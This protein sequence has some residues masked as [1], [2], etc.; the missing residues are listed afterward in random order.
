MIESF[1]S[2]IQLNRL[3]NHLT[4]KQISQQ[5]GLSKS[6]LSRVERNREGITFENAKLIF[7]IMDIGIVEEDINQQFEKD[8]QKFY[9]DT[10]YLNNYEKSYRVILDY[11]D[12][13][14]ASFSYVKYLLAEMIYKLLQSELKNPREYLYIEKY[15]DYLEDYQK[16]I[17][18]EIIGY[19][20][21]QK[22]MIQES[23]QYYDQALRQ[24]GNTLTKAIL[25]YYYSI[26]LK[27][28]NYLHQSLNLAMK[29]RQIFAETINV[30]RLLQISI[31]I[32]DIYSR[33][34][35]YEE[36]EELTL[37][38]LNAAHQYNLKQYLDNIYENILRNYMR[39]KQYH[40]IIDLENDLIDKKNLHHS[41][42]FCLSFAYYQIQQ[43]DKAKEYIK[44]AKKGT[45][46]KTRYMKTMINAFDVYLS[47]K[48]HDKKECQLLKA[49]QEAKKTYD[50]YLIIFTAE[51][52]KDF[53]FKIGKEH[54][55]YEYMEEIMYYYQQKK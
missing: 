21:I 31:Q 45:Y 29:A 14:K 15:F 23:M 25:Y 8:F 19:C 50:C 27:K 40:K 26:L 37:R 4:L 13:V 12:K 22:N 48:H 16:Q 7:D 24:K 20:Y 44:L 42:C 3:Q 46:K 55:A 5:T 6:Y 51:I 39:S 1:G 52:L 18:Y 28:N 53:Y 41:F 32:G 34:G 9:E 54:Q 36:A 10:V 49:Y 33:V 43:I 11:Q 38:S 35:Q 47:D 17:Y 30:P 2:I